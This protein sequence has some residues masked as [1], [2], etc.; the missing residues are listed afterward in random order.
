MP[1]Q[2]ENAGEGSVNR[3]EVLAGAAGLGWAALSEAKD[4]DA[5]VP[6]KDAMK[7]TRLETFLVKPRGC[8]SRSTQT[9]A[10]L[11]SANRSSKGGQGLVRRRSRKSSLTSSAR[12]RARWST[13]GRRSTAMPSTAAG[14]S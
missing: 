9:P 7:I 13:T 6:H 1:Q 11:G 14:R 8:S 12:I 5:P 4:D 2:S 3:R 10:L